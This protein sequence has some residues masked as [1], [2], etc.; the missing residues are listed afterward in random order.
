[1]AIPAPTP[2]RPP[3]I[4]PGGEDFRRLFALALPITLVQVGMQTPAVVGN[5]ILGHVSSPDLA[6]GTLGNLYVMTASGLG[7]GILM[8]LDPIVSQAAGAGDETALRHGIVRGVVLALVL[9][10][11]TA[12]LLLPARAVFAAAHQPAEV[13]P[14][15]ARYVR[16]SIGSL[17][18]LFVFVALRQSLQAL[19]RTAPVVITVI[20]A[21]LVNL[22]L[23]WA[24]IHGAAGVPRLGAV[25]AAIAGTLLRWLMMLALLGFGWRELG[26]RL[27]HRD[28]ETFARQPLVRMLALGFPIGIQ[29]VLEIGVFSLVGLLMGHLGTATVSAHQVAINVASLTYMVPLGVSIAAAVLVG[30]AIGAGDA[31]GARRAAVVA[32]I[33]GAGFMLLSGFTLSLFPRFFAALYTNDRSVIEITARLLMLAAVFQVFDGIQVVGIGILRGAGDTRVPMLVNLL[34]YWLLG[35]PVSLLLGFGLHGGAVGMWWGLVAGLIVVA[36]VI[37]ARVAARMRGSLVRV[38]IET[39]DEPIPAA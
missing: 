26:P 15:A 12:L 6:A 5:V 10:A 20:G 2:I 23:S 34:G 11:L 18:P 39:A 29:L 21:N 35:P 33:T 31:P 24:L 7:W 4:R 9:S 13:V 36:A 25:G 3:G 30:R 22:P 16:I 37:L 27:R 28:R 1:M 19:R 8:A 38:P 14:L 17:T 32:L